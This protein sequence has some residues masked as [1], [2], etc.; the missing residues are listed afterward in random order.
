MNTNNSKTTAESQ[1]ENLTG[2]RHL[3]T[4]MIFERVRKYLAD[5]PEINSICECDLRTLIVRSAPDAGYERY[6]PKNLQDA[7][8][9]LVKYSRGTWEFRAHIPLGANY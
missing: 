8:Q 9:L 1:I 2:E 7:Y 5:H 3:S 6:S 4:N